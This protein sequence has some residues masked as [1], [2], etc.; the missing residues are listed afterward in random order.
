MTVK[1]ALGHPA[2]ASRAEAAARRSAGGASG[3]PGAGQGP[4]QDDPIVKGRLERERMGQPY[5]ERLMAILTP[6]QQSM[7]PGA[8]KIDPQGAF[9]EN[10]GRAKGTA[11]GGVEAVDAPLPKDRRTRAPARR[12]PRQAAGGGEPQAEPDGKEE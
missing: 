1:D 12:D 2:A 8:V 6:E 10:E 4:S 9:K 5:R 7:M 11:I 3:A